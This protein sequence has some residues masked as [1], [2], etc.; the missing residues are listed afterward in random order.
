M[1]SYPIRWGIAGPGHIA[2]TFVSGLEKTA[3]GILVAV[4]SSSLDRAVTFARETGK[5]LRCYGSYAEMAND[6]DVDAAY[7]STLN[8][9]H[10][11]TAT[12]FLKAGKAVLCEKPLAMNARQVQGL[13]DVARRGNAFLMEGLWSR[14][15]PAI[16]QVGAWLADRRIGELISAQ[17]Q[18]GVRFP[19]NPDSR[20][21]AKKLGGGALL[22]LGV[23]PLSLLQMIFGRVPVSVQG[24]ACIGKTGVDEVFSATLGYGG[25]QFG[26]VAGS[27]LCPLDNT[28]RVFGSEGHIIVPDY[29]AATHAELVNGD[30]SEVW[31]AEQPA[32]FEPEIEAVMASLRAG[33]TECPLMTW[34]D[35]LIVA[36]TMDKL[37]RDWNFHYDG[38]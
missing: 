32:G 30:Q 36:Q 13:I 22:D 19:E 18:F 16:R 10:A 14:F 7:I 3:G 31:Q 11:S 5:P 20:I 24:Q 8:P 27:L 34:S 35:S 6:P 9:F 38:E 15:L 17:A 25:R 28:L 26:Y 33:Q 21:F 29:W 2:K 23:Y 4:A 12:L 1:S 37:R